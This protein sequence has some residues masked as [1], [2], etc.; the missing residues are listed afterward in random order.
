MTLPTTVKGTARVEARGEI[1]NLSLDFC[2]TLKSE[3]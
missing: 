2:S 1:Q 3:K